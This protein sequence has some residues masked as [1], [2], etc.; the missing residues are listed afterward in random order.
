MSI[1]VYWLSRGQPLVEAFSDGQ[2]GEALACAETQRKEKDGAGQ[3]LNAHVVISTELGDCVGKAGVSDE[4]PEGYSWTKSH[5][6]AAP[7]PDGE[8]KTLA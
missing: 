1:A 6:G 8:P 4:L 2:L 7:G 3:P 5:R